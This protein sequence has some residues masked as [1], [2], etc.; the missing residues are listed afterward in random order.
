MQTAGTI[1]ELTESR[2]R[3]C[4]RLLSNVLVLA[5]FSAMGLPCS[6]QNSIDTLEL[7]RPVR[8]WEFLPVTGTRAAIF[9]KET[10]PFEAWVYPLKILRDFKLRFHTA[11]MDFPAESMARTVTVRPESASVLYASDTFTARE[12]LFVPVHE[13]GAVIIIEVDAAEPIEQ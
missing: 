10:G 13:S 1:S 12:T 8:S 7:T 5:L 3:Q 11:T 6:A 4:S 2:V 9:G